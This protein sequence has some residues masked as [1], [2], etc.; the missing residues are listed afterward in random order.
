[1]FLTKTS[2]TIFQ[3]ATPV[4]K[5][6]RSNSIQYSIY[7]LLILL[8]PT[9][10][11]HCTSASPITQE[12]V[13]DISQAVLQ[14]D[15]A[16]LNK[17]VDIPRI[18]SE[19]GLFQGDIK[20]SSFQ[21]SL[22]EII[23]SRKFHP[24]TPLP[25]RMIEY[26]PNGI[27]YYD[28]SSIKDARLLKLINMATNSL[29][30]ETQILIFIESNPTTVDYIKFTEND[31]C[32]SYLGKQGGPQEIALGS[33]S[34]R[35]RN[36]I[37]HQ[38]LHALGFVHE[39]SRPDRD[40]N[41]EID[42][43]NVADGKET[44][45]D[46]VPEE[47]AL[48]NGT[49][50]Q[51]ES[52]MHSLK[53]TSSKETRDGYKQTIRPLLSKNGF[54]NFGSI[55]SL[56]LIDITRIKAI[57]YPH[58]VSQGLWTEWSH[59]SPCSVTCSSG[60]KSRTRICFKSDSTHVCPGS[61]FE[62]SRCHKYACMGEVR[63]EWGEWGEWSLCS[64]SCDGGRQVRVRQCEGADVCTKGKGRQYRTCGTYKCPGAWND[65]TPWS[66]CSQTCHYGKASRTRV[67]N[68]ENCE[69]P[70]T[71]T[72]ICNYK[73]LCSPAWEEWSDWTSCTNGK[74]T[75]T[76]RC[77][78]PP[79]RCRGPHTEELECTTDIDTTEAL[80]SSGELQT[81]DTWSTWSPCSTS[82][83][84]GDQTRAN[85]CGNLGECRQVRRCQITT[86]CAQDSNV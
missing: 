45:F 44:Y 21:Q 55:N 56:T 12:P 47:L 1:M 10:L 19:L 62:L 37:M 40:K 32:W 83:G 81:T 72:K 51:Y 46:I 39:E 7:T 14:D 43:E 74:V 80:N 49:N 18:N 77:T 4:T 2:K 75:R 28:T 17:A 16:Q 78:L 6:I 63:P 23:T 30:W 68:G 25:E 66:A 50:Y 61:N 57:Y 48:T 60:L 41:V 27:I 20:L 79:Y 11:F 64:A 13:A 33:H 15:S 84:P 82:C 42:F 58:A 31:G 53:K 3:S 52:I 38:I 69:G 36:V 34:C 35:Y 54:D 71:K 26:W 86:R 85:S 65:W 22:Y 24:Q 76:R 9:L 5:R 67:C 73:V 8:L 29:I 70:D 59:W